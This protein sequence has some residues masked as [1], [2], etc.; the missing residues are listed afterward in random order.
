MTIRFA[1][2]RIQGI[3]AAIFEAR[4]LVDT[5]AGCEE[6]LGQ[7][8]ARARAGGLN[9]DKSALAYSRGRGVRCYGTPDLV[10]FLENNGL[11]RRWTHTLTA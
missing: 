1:H 4:P 11:P 9:I 7:L 10:R 6:A 8:T 3:D 5:D 2:V